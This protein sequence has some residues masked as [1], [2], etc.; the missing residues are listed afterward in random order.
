MLHTNG[1]CQ[2]ELNKLISKAPGQRKVDFTIQVNVIQLPGAFDMELRSIE[3][4]RVAQPLVDRHCDLII[5]R[6]AHGVYSLADIFRELGWIA[7]HDTHSL[8]GV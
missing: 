2:V 8:A 4:C 1:F 6:S 5:Q 7:S 3:A